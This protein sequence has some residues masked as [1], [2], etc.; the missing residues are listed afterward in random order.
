LSG[1]ATRRKPLSGPEWIRALNRLVSGNGLSVPVTLQGGEPSTHPHFFSIIA[2]LD[3][4]IPIDI[5]T[6]LQFDPH[7]L[8][9][10]VRPERLRRAA[11]YASIRVSYHPE[12]MSLGVLLEKT[13]L[14]IAH[15][16]RVGI[17][18][19]LHP[20]YREEILRAQT[21]ALSRG[22]DFRTKEFLGEHQGVLHGTYRYDGAVASPVLKSCQCRTSELL[23]AP[24][25]QVHRCHHD[26]YNGVLPLGSLLDEGFAIE[27]R[28][29][30]CSFFGNC[31]PCDVK[32]KTNRHQ[33]YGHTSVEIEAIS[34]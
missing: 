34:C 20:D 23:I 14:L 33:I 30:P 8:I 17:Y 10:E 28:F 21:L 18:G 2:G 5:L 12:T 27:D 29:R 7:R 9:R 24:D 6:N 32:V 31:N 11:H 1:Q 3:E 19:V 16:F 25:G 26:L 4:R 13:E 22:L 15:G